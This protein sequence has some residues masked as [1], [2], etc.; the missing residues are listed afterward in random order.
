MTL[1]FGANFLW[2][3][4]K[5]YLGFFIL[6]KRVNVSSFRCDVYGL[7]KSHCASFPIT[8]TKISHPFFIIHFAI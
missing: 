2:L 7:E 6:K 3:S 5:Q 4:K 8:L 1:L